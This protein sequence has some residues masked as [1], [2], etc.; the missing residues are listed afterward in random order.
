MGI[1]VARNKEVWRLVAFYFL[2]MFIFAFIHS[3]LSVICM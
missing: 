1:P 3:V 2:A